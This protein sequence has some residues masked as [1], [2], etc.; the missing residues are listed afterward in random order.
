MYGMVSTE[1]LRENLIL[2]LGAK[3]QGGS[4]LKYIFSK[5]LLNDVAVSLDE[6]KMK[7]WNCSRSLHCCATLFPKGYVE[8]CVNIWVSTS[9]ACTDF[10]YCL[11]ELQGNNSARWGTGRAGSRGQEIARRCCQPVFNVERISSWLCFTASASC[12]DGLTKL[13]CVVTYVLT[14][15]AFIQMNHSF[16]GYICA[17]WFVCCLSCPSMKPRDKQHLFQ[18][19]EIG[20]W[21]VFLY[22]VFMCGPLTSLLPH[23]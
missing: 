6:H 21:L 2:V 14:S 16:C 3:K 17:D 23:L 20:S 15:R 11:M 9:P 4:P 7:T 8:F 22:F 5:M 10:W 1:N 12:P 19:S 13:C 18:E